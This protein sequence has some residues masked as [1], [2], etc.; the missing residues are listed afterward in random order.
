[1]VNLR[2]PVAPYH[3]TLSPPLIIIIFYLQE[4][5]NAR[6]DPYRPNEFIITY[7]IVSEPSYR[8][9]RFLHH[10]TSSLTSIP[11]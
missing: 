11:V 10:Y 9:G 5:G 2:R 1:M 6:L 4:L 3:V 7:N 8:H